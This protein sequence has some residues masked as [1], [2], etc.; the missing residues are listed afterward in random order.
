MVSI[1]ATELRPG[2]VVHLDPKVLRERGGCKTNAAINDGNDR[3]VHG[4]H[5]FLV[6]R[7][8][9]DYCTAAPLFSQHTNGSD[10]L[11]ED[12]KTGLADKWID[13]PSYTSRWQHWKI[14]LESVAAASGAEESNPEYRRSYAANDSAVLDEILHWETENRCP[15]R[16]V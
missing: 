4:L 9:E 13:T 11:A 2:L 14:P 3:A 6:L 15:Y 10:R 16:S 7:V 12:L 8:N 1:E 5:Y